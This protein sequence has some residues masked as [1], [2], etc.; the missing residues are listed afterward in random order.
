MTQVTTDVKKE[1]TPHGQ[2]RLAYLACVH[3]L[4]G[5]RVDHYKKPTGDP[6]GDGPEDSIGEILCS[7]CTS[8]VKSVGWAG[9]AF[10]GPWASRVSAICESSGESILEHRPV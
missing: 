7:D 10:D 4:D 3:V 2:T 6:L 1:L 9:D 5:E 8:L